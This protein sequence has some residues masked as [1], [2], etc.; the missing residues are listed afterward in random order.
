MGFGDPYE[1]IIKSLKIV[2]TSICKIPPNLPFPKGGP[3]FRGIWQR[4]DREI[5]QCLYQFNPETA[6]KHM[7]RRR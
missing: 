2:K 6:I 4:R 7:M 3:A 1:S 5:F